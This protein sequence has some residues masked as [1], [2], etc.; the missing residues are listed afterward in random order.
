[1]SNT[2]QTENGKEKM[3]M[4]TEKDYTNASWH[5]S[6]TNNGE[7]YRFA[8]I[9]DL[10]V[11]Q[12]RVVFPEN[13]KRRMNMK[14]LTGK[15]MLMDMEVKGTGNSYLIMGWETIPAMSYEFEDMFN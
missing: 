7:H 6:R 15:Y 3:T 14:A 1:M 12:K 9:K 5:Y 4:L 8:D 2:R 11:T 10:F 13:S